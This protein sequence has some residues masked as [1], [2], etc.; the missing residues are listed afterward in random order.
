VFSVVLSVWEQE[1]IIAR[2]VQALLNTTTELWE[3]IVVFDG[4]TDD[5]IGSVRLAIDTA[6]LPGNLVHYLF[7]NQPTSVYETSSNNLGM[8][9]ATPGTQ[10]IVLV[11]DDMKMI[12]RGWN[13]LLAFPMRLYP[14][15][16]A[17]SGRCAHPYY[18]EAGSSAAQSVKPTVGRCGTAI[19]LPLDVPVETLC[20]FHVRDTV[21]RGPLL[22]NATKVA[23]LG[24][25]DEVHFFL[26][27]DDHDL[28]MRG[29]FQKNWTAG[30]MPLD[31]EAP[32]ENGA[33]RKKGRS[34]TVQE[35]QYLEFRKKL[36]L[37]GGEYKAPRLAPHHD[38]D[39]VIPA[40]FGC[41]KKEMWWMTPL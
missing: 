32:L 34:K 12:W 21:N 10:F 18:S 31:F 33:V 25:L 4:C 20:T 23:E 27:Y 41:G 7:I 11:Q 5:S 22:L 37:A 24:Y 36:Q 28:M 40:Q 15:V 13:T 17:V 6:T 8:R 30:W 9:A 38:A 1:A 3:L 26:G 39:L 29:W 14:S 19:D 2:H 35:L 16:L